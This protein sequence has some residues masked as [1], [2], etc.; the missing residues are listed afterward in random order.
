[1]SVKDIVTIIFSST[2]IT[3][4]ITTI[5]NLFTNKKKDAIENITKER[6][7]WRDEL[8]QISL[9]IYKSKNLRE[10]K[11]AVSELKV[12][13]N[14]YGMATNSIFNDTLIWEDIHKLE[15]TKSMTSKEFENTKKK[16]VNLISCNLK[17]DWER[18]KSEIRGNTQTKIVIICLSVSF[19]LYSIRWFYNY[20]LTDGKVYNY[21]SFCA[22]YMLF[23]G[24]AIFLIVVADKWKNKIQLYSH[25]IGVFTIPIIIYLLIR[26]FVPSAIPQTVIDYIILCAPYLALIYASEMKALF[27][28]R[29]MAKYILSITLSTG[30]RT[31]D[32]KYSVFFV[33]KKY[34]N[35]LTGEDIVIG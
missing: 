8:R 6:K 26:Y 12:R 4:V 19:L 9:R 14:A 20:S 15:L 7:T 33:S 17:H 18:S 3:T 13:I 16:F 5:F 21:L 11:T 10:L 27:Y 1:M 25:V 32:S 22:M 23:A 2:L 24:F 30:R 28:R 34:K 35:R 29:N 31:I